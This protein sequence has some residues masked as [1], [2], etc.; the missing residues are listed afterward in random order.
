MTARGA[1]L[2]HGRLGMRLLVGVLVLTFAAAVVWR[3]TTPA[4]AD[5]G[6]NVPRSAGLESKLGVRFVQ[7]AV[8]A[9]GGIVELRYQ[10][11]DAQK[12]SKFQRNV[13]HPPVLRSGSR[14]GS[15]YRTALMR[16]GHELRPGQDYYILYLNNNHAVRPGETLEI[17]AGDQTLAKVPVR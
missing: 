16:Q 13:K 14:P 7:A 6:Y 15:L 11:L 10:V 12:A 9:D 17:D 1:R 2:L 3:T 8:V 4:Q 5:R